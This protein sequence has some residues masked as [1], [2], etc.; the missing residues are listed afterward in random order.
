MHN[1]VSIIILCYNGEKYIAR[2]FNSILAQT[3]DKIEVI[4]VDD[5]ST[6]NSKEQILSYQPLLADKG[7]EFKYIYQQNQG[8]GGAVNTGLKCFTGDYFCLVDIDDYMMPE[9]IEKKAIFLSNHSD[10]DIVRNNGYYVYENKLDQP[11]KL[12]VTSQQEKNNQHIFEDLV[13]GSTNN[14]PGSYLIRSVA[15]L[16]QVPNREIYISRFGQNLQILMLVACYGKSG[17]IDEPLLKYV[18]HPQAHSCASTLERQMELTAGYED[19]RKT[20][21]STMAIDQKFYCDIV[22]KVFAKARLRTAFK[23]K[24]SEILQR[25]YNILS[26]MKSLNGYDRLIFFRGKYRFVDACVQAIRKG[27]ETAKK[28]VYSR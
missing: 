13:A 9:A 21:I 11:I 19:I 6:D 20:I 27:L 7:Y 15:F 25:Q 23:Y 16:K 8:I 12:F 3:Y 18:R 17:F 14:W 22:D 26:D 2:C 28:I 5:G 4:I 24:D 1:K 10:F